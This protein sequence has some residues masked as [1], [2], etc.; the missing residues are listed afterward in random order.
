MTFIQAL[1]MGIIQGLTEFLPISSSAHIVLTSHL[2]SLFTG[3]V[4]AATSEHEIFFDIIIHLGTLFA[5]LIY[6]RKEI[7]EIIRDFYTAIKTKDFS[8]ENAKLPIYIVL[9]T[10]ITGVIVLPLKDITETITAKPAIVG[11]LL[12]VTG[13]ILYFSEFVSQKFANKT[14]RVTLKQ[15]LFMGLA[16]GL[17][18]IPGISRS[19]STISAGLFFGLNKVKAAKYSFLLSIPIILGASMLYPV[20]ELSEHQVAQLDWGILATGFFSSLIVG[21]LCIKYFL[22]FLQ[23]HS[24]KSFAYY[25]WIVG[26][27]MFV[28]FTFIG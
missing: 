21:Y 11:I 26:F 4:L 12:I 27:L 9:G 23:N 14:E 17:A 18:I 2:Y 5:I 10:F 22:K 28:G 24:M 15:A 13:F 16:Q 25:C 7:F 8:S 19:G 6:L 20:L 3:K 1:L